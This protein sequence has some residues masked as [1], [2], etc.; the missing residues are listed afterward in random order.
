MKKRRE[1]QHW[2]THSSIPMDPEYVQLVKRPMAGVSLPTPGAPAWAQKISGTQ[3]EDMVQKAL[4]AQQASPAWKWPSWELPY[5][6]AFQTGSSTGLNTVLVVML[7]SILP[8][9]LPT[10]RQTRLLLRDPSYLFS[11]VCMGTPAQAQL[12]TACITLENK[13]PYVHSQK[14]II[15]SVHTH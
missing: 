4:Q 6:P 7:I 15:P 11:S 12:T 2:A 14:V 10:S 13:A 1:V 9:S 5:L 8:I 3:W